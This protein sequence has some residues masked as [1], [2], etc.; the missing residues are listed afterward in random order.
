MISAGTET[1]L[2]FVSC[3]F[4]PR[5]TGSPVE[6]SISPVCFLEPGLGETRTFSVRKKTLHGRSGRRQEKHEGAGPSKQPVLLNLCFSPQDQSL[7]DRKS[8]V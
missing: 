8:V 3:G 4:V 5:V 2:T 1:A 6:H 7:L